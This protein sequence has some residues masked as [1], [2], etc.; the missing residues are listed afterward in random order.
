MSINNYELSKNNFLYRYYNFIVKVKD[1]FLYERY[2]ERHPTTLS[3]LIS[4]SI[5]KTLWSLLLLFIY[6]FLILMVILPVFSFGWIAVPFTCVYS[7]IFIW[8]ASDSGA[9]L[10]LRNRLAAYDKTLIWPDGD[11]DE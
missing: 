8:V 4:A 2:K 11:N 7:L 10:M 1:F 6:S 9:F 3:D 5:A